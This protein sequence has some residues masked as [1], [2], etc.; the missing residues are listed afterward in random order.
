[1]RS[2]TP[3]TVYLLTEIP[4]PGLPV[5][6]LIAYRDLVIPSRLEQTLEDLRGILPLSRQANDI[7]LARI[8]YARDERIRL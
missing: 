4:I 8:D 3:K 5:D 2:S 1:M 6:V 7:D